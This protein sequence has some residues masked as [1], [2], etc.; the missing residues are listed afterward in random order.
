MSG[1]SLHQPKESISSWVQKHIS[2]SVDQGNPRLQSRHTVH[3]LNLHLSAVHT[4]PSSLY[5]PPLSPL[6][7]AKTEK[8]NGSEGR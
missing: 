5:S 8:N 3:Y 6:T 1:R 7:L 2:V 4:A